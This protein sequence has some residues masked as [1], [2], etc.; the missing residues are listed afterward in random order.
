VQVVSA[1]AKAEPEALLVV[2]DG[3]RPDHPE[4]A[5]NCRLARAVVEAVDWGCPVLTHYA[6]TNMGLKNRV[7]TGITWAF[8]QVDRAIILEDD[9]VPDPS[10]FPFCSELLTRYKDDQR[11]MAIAGDNFQFGKRRAPYSYY[12]SIY[13]HC[14]GWATW[15]RAW[16][17]YDHSISLWPE[18]QDG[19]WLHDILMD[20]QAERYWARALDGQHSGRGNSWASR[21]TFCCWLQNGLTALPSMNLVSNIG[22]RADATHTRDPGSR[23]AA[24]GAESVEFPLKHPPYIIRD[25][26]ADAYTAGIL[27]R[28]PSLPRRVAGRARR[29]LFQRR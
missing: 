3:P 26:A 28:T 2:A 14:W 15:R 17:H 8:E 13:P 21:W 16:R 9:C 5:E 1:I 12:F 11:I 6:D 20:E 23:V 25:V 4:D 7:S 27:Y 29:T 22:F 10:F 19:G 24:L 18:I